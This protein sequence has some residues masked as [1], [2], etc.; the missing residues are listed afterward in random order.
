MMMGT[1]LVPA[2]HPDQSEELKLPSRRDNQSLLKM[3]A[4]KLGL[5]DRGCYIAIALA[6]IVFFLLLIIIAMIVSWPGEAGWLEGM[7]I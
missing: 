5:N 6:I 4:K 7:F 3:Y 1:S 2:H